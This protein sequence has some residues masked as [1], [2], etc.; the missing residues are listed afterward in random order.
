MEHKTCT[1]AGVVLGVL[2][3]CIPAPG[4][5][6][7][8]WRMDGS[9]R[10]PDA[11]PP[12]H[13]GVDTNVAWVVPIDTDTYSSPVLIGGK[14]ITTAG[15]AAVICLDANTGKQL[16]RSDN[17]YFKDVLTGDALARAERAR[18]EN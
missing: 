3:R 7:F 1:V 11:D 14:V 2:W 9:G 13:W 12:I 10:Y 5:E 15:P 17:H 18:D 8:G 6:V 16:W 4:G